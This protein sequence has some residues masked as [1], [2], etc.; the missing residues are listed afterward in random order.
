MLLL[1]VIMLIDL[2]DMMDSKKFWNRV[3]PSFG[4]K[5]KAINVTLV[6]NRKLLIHEKQLVQNF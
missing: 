4:K 2:S 3:K 5:M 1:F 6:K